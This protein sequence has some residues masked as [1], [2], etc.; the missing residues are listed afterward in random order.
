VTNPAVHSNQKLHALGG[1]GLDSW[2]IQA[3]AFDLTVWD[4][5][6]GKNAS[7][8]KEQQKQRGTGDPVHIVIPPDSDFF[9]LSQGPSN[10]L[11]GVI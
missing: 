11:G 9:A 8:A 4:M 5:M 3:V 2:H 7:G 10:D 1:Q 6:L